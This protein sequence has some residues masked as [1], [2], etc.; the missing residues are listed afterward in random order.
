MM[1]VQLQE[2]DESLR[3]KESAIKSAIKQLEESLTA[4]IQE[5]ETHSQKF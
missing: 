2:K 4:K 3:M 5:L 1:E